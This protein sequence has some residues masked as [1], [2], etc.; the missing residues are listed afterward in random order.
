V[1]E[2]H[3]VL[4]PAIGQRQRELLERHV[5]DHLE[6]SDAELGRPARLRRRQVVHPV[7]DVVQGSHQAVDE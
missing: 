6:G 5:L 2:H 7:A 4:A 3:P 1:I